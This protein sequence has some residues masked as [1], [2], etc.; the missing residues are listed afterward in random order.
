[1][2]GIRPSGRL[3]RPSGSEVSE[4]SQMG[5]PSRP[6]LPSSADT[7]MTETSTRARPRRASRSS[8]AV[9]NR[10]IVENGVLPGPQ[11]SETLPSPPPSPSRRVS[12]KDRIV[13]H[14]WT[15][16]TL[17]RQAFPRLGKPAS[18]LSMKS[19]CSQST[20][21]Q[22]TMSTGGIAN[23]LYTRELSSPLSS[24]LSHLHR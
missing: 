22:Q 2:T 12:L 21:G 4:A 19:S 7:M 20:P 17:V 8:S 18:R 11:R 14:R 6:S 5:A 10:Q 13:C 9:V 16:F 24:L 3:G 1:V 23:I 15:W